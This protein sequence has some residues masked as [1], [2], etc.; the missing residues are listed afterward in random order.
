MQYPTS[1]KDQL[2][3]CGSGRVEHP[4]IQEIRASLKFMSM[5]F[6]SQGIIDLPNPSI[7]TPTRQLGAFAEVRR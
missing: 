2:R 5:H 1:I 4:P 7:A 3:S 6:E